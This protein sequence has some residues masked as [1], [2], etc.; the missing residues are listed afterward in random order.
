MYKRFGAILILLQLILLLSWINVK[1]LQIN[2]LVST[3]AFQLRFMNEL[4][5]E[6]E[7]SFL[8]TLANTSSGQRVVDYT[9]LENA[10]TL[11]ITESDYEVLLKIVEAEAGGEDY[12]GKLLV[13]NVVMNRV[14]SQSFPDTI[15]EVVFQ[16]ENG[17]T[18][19]SPV[20]DGRIN[21]VSIS[22][23]TIDAV[24]EALKGEDV[25]Q[26]ALY[27]VARKY[28]DPDKMKW[29]DNHLT[30]LFSHGGHEFFL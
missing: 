7:S 12:T 1:G 24:N 3:P 13:A 11:Q 17:Q 16:K 18:Q 29:F 10:P 26:G 23:D 2:R 9:I 14:N 22:N 28:A 4:I 30:L 8:C 5:I 15:T 19:F 21:K 20:S 6:E 27:F 25:S